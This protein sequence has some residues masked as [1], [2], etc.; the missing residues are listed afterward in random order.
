MWALMQVMLLC[1]QRHIGSAI[2]IWVLSQA[3]QCDQ[4]HIALVVTLWKQAV[5]PYSQSH[6]DTVVTM[7]V[8]LQ[9]IVLCS[10][11]YM[12]SDG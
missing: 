7:W 12:E 9:A 6:I 8:L 5:V 3:V 2:T 4:R 11:R 10:Q 1:S